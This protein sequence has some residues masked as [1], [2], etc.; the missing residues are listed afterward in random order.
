MQE[1]VGWLRQ[2]LT[3]PVSRRDLAA[4]LYVTPEHINAMFKK[5]LGISPTQFVHRE[6]VL[7]ANRLMLTEGLSVKEAAA[8]T[9]FC[10][11]FYFSKV[12]KKVMGVPPSRA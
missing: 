3:E 2:H 10:D 5:E 6:R 4:R 8:R 12:F 11:Q 9:G 7:L 1:M